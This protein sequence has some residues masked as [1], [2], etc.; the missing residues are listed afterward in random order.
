MIFLDFL[1]GIV[2]EITIIVLLAGLL[3]ML[4]PESSLKR[5]VKVVMGLFVIIS[6]LVPVVSLLSQD[7]SWAVSA[8]QWHDEELKETA[9]IIATGKDI[10]SGMQEAAIEECEQRLNRQV[11]ALVSLVPEVK[12]VQATVQTRAGRAGNSWGLLEN[13]FLKIGLSG[14]ESTVSKSKNDQETLPEG[15]FSKEETLAVSQAFSESQESSSLGLDLSIK[16]VAP[17]NIQD[18][19]SERQDELKGGGREEIDLSSIDNLSITTKQKRVEKQVKDLVANF[20]SVNPEK[21][22]IK[23]Y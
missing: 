18:T 16:P 8:W 3:E 2:R 15:E 14:E 20:Y 9:G 5:F 6:I 12:W 11:E 23:F 1:R 10:S 21:V 19:K 4:L 17:I 7:Y 22:K 13:V